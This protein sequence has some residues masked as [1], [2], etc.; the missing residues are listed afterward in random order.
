MSDN[1]ES[2][3]DEDLIQQAQR[4]ADEQ[5]QD[6]DQSDSP[7]D[8]LAADEFRT[9]VDVAQTF[10]L[11][12]TNIPYSA[13]KSE[14][15]RIFS[16]QG[17][18]VTSTRMCYDGYGKEKRFKG[19]AFVDLGDKMSYEKAL[20][21]DK[22]IWNASDT[23]QNKSTKNPQSNA[24]KTMRTRQ[25]RI[26][27]RPTK[28]KNELKQ[29]VEKT[30]ERVA[31]IKRSHVLTSVD[32]DKAESEQADSSKKVK[33]RKHGSIVKDKGT[34]STTSTMKQSKYSKSS[35]KRLQIRSKEERGKS[36]LSSS[37]KKKRKLDTVVKGEDVT[38]VK[39]SKQFKKR[40]PKRST[41]NKEKKPTSISG[42][43]KLE[44]ST[45]KASKKERAKK[46]AILMRMKGK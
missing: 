4:W 11:H 21:L 34:S 35:K 19:V 3:D 18:F 25:R 22:T 2:S 27:V 17:C 37:K 29:I 26:N 33:K 24:S 45:G 43:K 32:K 23:A 16:C 41:D 36:E 12:I 7:K 42:D 38:P 30:K 14:I 8:D 46:A 40:S 28:S 20:K 5:Q 10:S 6:E 31:A 13:T 15:F 9:S 44:K 39:D 1:G